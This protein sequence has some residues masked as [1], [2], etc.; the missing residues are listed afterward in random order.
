MWCFQRKCPLE[1]FIWSKEQWSLRHVHNQPRNQPPDDRHT[2]HIKRQISNV[3]FTFEQ[4]FQDRMYSSCSYKIFSFDLNDND[5]I[6]TMIPVQ[7]LKSFTLT[8]FVKCMEHT[9]I[10]ICRPR[11]LQCTHFHKNHELRVNW[12][13]STKKRR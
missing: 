7:A 3:Q 8:N 10:L 11:N 12:H 6:Q 13:T 5:K 4:R 9:I 1:K 2:K